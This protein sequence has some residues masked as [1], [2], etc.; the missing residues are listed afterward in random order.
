VANKKLHDFKAGKL[1][2]PTYVRGKKSDSLIASTKSRVVRGLIGNNESTASF[3]YSPNSALK[4][5]QQIP[6]D[7]SLF[8]NH[9]FFDSAESKVNIAFNQIFNEYPFDGTL[10]QIEDFEDKLSGFEKYI[11]DQIPKNVG[12]L[13]FSGTQTGES[14]DNGTYISV[15][16]SEGVKFPNF[17]RNASAKSVLDPKDKSFTFEMHLFLPEIENDN[18]VIAQKRAS[19]AKNITV[20]ISASSSTSTC[21]LIFGVTSGSSNLYASTT[22]QKGQFNY[23]SAQFVRTVTENQLRIFN[24]SVLSVT[25]SNSFEMG[26]LLFNNQNLVIGSGSA[27]RLNSTIF[28]PQQTLSGA[29]D[30]FRYYHN[31]KTVDSVK[32]DQYVSVES[33]DDLKLYYKF[34]EPNGSYNANNVVL[35]ASGN[36]LHNV[37]QNFDISLRNTGSLSTPLLRENSYRSPVLF[38]DI[39]SISS[40]NIELLTSA[41][42]Y[43]SVNPNLITKLVPVHYFLEGQADGGWANQNGTLSNPITQNSIPGTAV[44]GAAQN[45]ITFLL[46]WARHF[47]QLKIFIDHFSKIYDVDY[48]E[49]DHVADN[50]LRYLGNHYN[51]PLPRLFDSSDEIQFVNGDLILGEQRR[52]ERALKEI[53]NTIWRRILVNA[54]EFRQTKGTVYSVKAALRAA[55]V[56]IDNLFEVREY[57]GNTVKSL[58]GSRKER[59]EVNRLLTFSGSLA[60]DTGTLNS[61][62]ISSG[63]PFLISPF[64]SG[65]RIETG[66]PEIA[67]T[68]V[69]KSQPDFP[70]GI[71]ND[72]SDGL[73][74][75]GSFSFEALYKFK[76]LITGS[77][78][79]TQSL[80]R[81]AVTGSDASASSHGIIFNLLLIS[82]SYPE[83]TLFGRPGTATSSENNL[84]LRIQ[85]ASLFDGDQWNV[86]FS[87]NRFTNSVSSSYSLKVGK[88][89]SGK[90]VN[91]YATSSFFLEPSDGNQDNNT[92]QKISSQYNA[93][94]SFLLIGSQSLNTSGDRF[95]NASSQGLLQKTTN[96]AGE[97]NFIRF[98]SKDFSNQEWKE[99]VKNYKS[100]GV[101]DPNVNYNFSTKIS[102]SFQRMRIDTIGRQATTASDGS[103][104]FRLFDF[105]QNEL[106]LDGTGFE[107]STTLIKPSYVIRSEW[108]PKFDVSS[109]DQKVRIR[110][111]QDTSRFNANPFA[112]VS[113][114]YEI[115]S[116]EVSIDDTRFTIDLSTVKALNEDIMTLFSNLDYF[117]DNLGQPNLLFGESYQ[118][119]E[120]LRET[121]F[122]NL[123]KK[124]DLMTYSNIFKWFNAAYSELV[125][126]MIPSKTK[127]L[128]INFVVESHVL[129]RHRLR[130]LFDQIY[131]RAIERNR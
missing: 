57:G 70:H 32:R 111:L 71:S 21:D 79:T 68:F 61:Q 25:S 15:N 97:I 41:S 67:G 54:S 12:Y 13:Y 120:N 42:E 125:Y 107:S 103:G 63:R 14:G 36:A 84:R 46:I 99:H 91:Y 102:G 48:E 50:F 2:S 113:P 40:L 106:H 10:K 33:S 110:S 124:I 31:Y 45:L 114:V 39:S 83:I 76:N 127:F 78:P 28:T 86:S 47:D 23:I 1:F 26:E 100:R 30:D 8:Q 35:D 53:Q 29:I 87:R 119:I 109:G 5:T 116:D 17:S 3:R 104:N 38:S 129:E 93:S 66:L 95:L 85:S 82:G 108:D 62:G 80:A 6:L 101:D 130:Y 24:N 52:A 90:L 73:F 92:L 18:Q 115:P 131:L 94:G 64:L 128:G 81:I 75:S 123:D 117:D 122:N 37:I 88:Q 126:S 16:D 72:P 34:N 98:W 96:F 49:N 121:Y 51:I 22:V 9:T 44:I 105:S 58:S 55:G 43:D 118:E 60:E 20:A 89:E 59:K 65:S 11:Y 69:N 19:L 7:Y 74:T 27:A 56:D 112:R 77:Y 4:S